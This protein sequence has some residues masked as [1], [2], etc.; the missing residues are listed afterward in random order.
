[1]KNKITVVGSYNTDLIIRVSRLPR[2]GETVF[3]GSFS[4]SPGG[5]GANQ[6]VAAARAGAEVCFIGCVGQDPFGDEALQQLRQNYINIDYVKRDDRVHTGAAYIIVNDAGENCIV[7]AGGA[8]T[9]LRP[10]DIEAAEAAIASSE[11]LVVQLESPLET[12]AAAVR[13]AAAKGV[14]V[15]LNPAPAQHLDGELLKRVTVITPNEI[16][17]EM[18]TGIKIKQDEGNLVAAAERLLA[19]GIQ[20]V[21]IT[22]GEK[23]VFAATPERLF[24][25]PAFKVDSVDTTGAGD[26][27]NGAF[28]AGFN[29]HLPL[30]AVVKFASAAAAISVAKMGAQNS[31]PF[32][33][34]IHRFLSIHGETIW[35]AISGNPI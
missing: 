24:C 34:E 25:V 26:V 29:E 19:A 13:L 35:P 32:L 7:V 23:G 8:N 9:C 17:C 1:M 12:V 14:K 16:E 31:A 15:I 33:E 21:L 28:A 10:A 30:E 2:P 11:V 27:F 18:L 4:K 22:R 20:A 6:A 3:G 5:K